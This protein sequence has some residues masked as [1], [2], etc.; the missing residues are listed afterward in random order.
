MNRVDR[1]VDNLDRNV[2]NLG[3]KADNLGKKADNI[4]ALIFLEGQ[5]SILSNH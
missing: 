1:K 5:I 2:D 3:K 4:K